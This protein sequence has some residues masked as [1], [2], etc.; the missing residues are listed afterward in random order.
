[1]PASKSF[2]ASIFLPF[3]ASDHRPARHAG[4]AE[5]VPGV[6][7]VHPAGRHVEVPRLLVGERVHH[8]IA[9]FRV[10]ARGDGVQVP[11]REL[12][13]EAL[14][15]ALQLHF[16]LAADGVIEHLLERLEPA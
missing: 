8:R 5:H 9:E 12:R 10:G 15:A 1:M 4:G 2:R 14:A 3:S 16:D 11:D 13:G 6:R 7:D